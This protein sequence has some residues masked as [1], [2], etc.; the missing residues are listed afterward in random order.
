MFEATSMA[1][2]RKLEMRM[3][4]RSRRVVI[5][6]GGLLARPKWC[7]IWEIG[8]GASGVGGDS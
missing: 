8:D 6:V 1:L 4:L 5:R 7:V 3:A 2:S